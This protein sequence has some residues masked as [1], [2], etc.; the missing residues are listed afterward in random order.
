MSSIAS[1]C[2]LPYP[3]SSP[4]HSSA[5]RLTCLHIQLHNVHLNCQKGRRCL[6]HPSENTRA[7]AQ[8]VISLPSPSLHSPSEH[9]LWYPFPALK[10]C[11][12]FRSN[13]RGFPSDQLCP[14][15]RT[16]GVVPSS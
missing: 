2:E 16:N 13:S 5:S 14:M 8:G 9:E 3:I 7:R 10:A 12:H 4:F 11:R 15:D 1:R 6:P